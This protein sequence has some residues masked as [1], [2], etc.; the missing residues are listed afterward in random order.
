MIKFTGIH[1]CQSLFF[2]K[3]AGLIFLMDKLIFFFFFCSA[4]QWTGF[5]MIGTSVMKGLVGVTVSENDKSQKWK[6]SNQILFHCQCNNI[7]HH[8][9]RLRIG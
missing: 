8:K 2:N 6:Y 4:N 3:V 9:A 7:G 1:L 5:Y